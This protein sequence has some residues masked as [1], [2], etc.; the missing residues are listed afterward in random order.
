MIYNIIRDGDDYVLTLLNSAMS[1][2]LY[3]SQESRRVSAEGET[4]L[5]TRHRRTELSYI[6]IIYYIGRYYMITDARG[7]CVLQNYATRRFI[8]AFI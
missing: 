5:Q 6:I 4:T 7:H 1:K 2:K 3:I 8:H